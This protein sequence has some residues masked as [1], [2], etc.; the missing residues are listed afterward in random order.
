[1]SASAGSYDPPHTKE[2]DFDVGYHKSYHATTTK[3]DGKSVTSDDETWVVGRESL[4]IGDCTLDTLIVDGK[5]ASPDKPGQIMILY[6]NF[7]PA[8][9]TFVRSTTISDGS[10]PSRVLFDKIEPLGR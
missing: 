4:V 1:M 7:S 8:L 10:P 6:G 9:R 3:S 5:M 2:P